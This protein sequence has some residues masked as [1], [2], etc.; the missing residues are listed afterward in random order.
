MGMLDGKVA[1]V[2]GAGHGIGRGHAMELARHGAT[3]I[4]ND[5]GG[6]V[7]GEGTGR[8]AD[9]TVKI[10]EERGGTAAANYA[11]VSDFDQAG[12]MIAQAVDDFGRLDIL[13]N[14]A[15]IVRD[16]SIFNMS[17][18]D[19]DAVL[20]VHVR[21]TWAPCK[22]AALHW[23]A[24]NKATGRKVDGRII[25]TVSGAGLTGNFGQSNYAPA[26]AAIASLTQTLSLELYKMGVTVNAVGPA[27][28]T[29]ITG[30]MPNAPAVIEAD[31]IA[32]DEWNRMDPAV[33][34]PLVA[35][36]AS[37]EADHVTGQIIRAVAENIILMKGWADG[38]TI[39]NKGQR[40]DATKLGQQLATDVFF[41][42]APGL[43]Y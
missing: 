18:D 11:D 38:P 31:E 37:D 42:R 1:I 26:K 41:T 9:L 14:N 32:E 6:S 35:W 8:D 36:L 43:R 4:V 27:A 7:T 17:V 33:S 15:G 2:T 12:D 29:R 10:I 21:G 3:V 20:K 24:L 22:H 28:A 39:N 25:N 40:W 34:S 13:V 23:R 30:T 16:G 5:L 19:F